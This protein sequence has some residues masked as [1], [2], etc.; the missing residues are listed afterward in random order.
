[1]QHMSTKI[2]H[3]PTKGE[4]TASR[5]TSKCNPRVQYRLMDPLIDKFFHEQD[6]GLIVDQLKEQLVLVEQNS[7]R[8]APFK[9]NLLFP[10]EKIFTTSDLIEVLNSIRTMHEHLSNCVWEYTQTPE[11]EPSTYKKGQMLFKATQDPELDPKSIF[12]YRCDIEPEL[13]Y[14][15]HS[16]VH[17]GR[18]NID[19]GRIGD[20]GEIRDVSTKWNWD[21]LIAETKGFVRN[22]PMYCR[23]HV[24]YDGSAKRLEIVARIDKQKPAPFT[25]DW[26]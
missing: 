21:A 26:K 12:E 18:L 15:H 8:T 10:K 9:K 19:C 20:D 3:T 13:T 11:Y 1:M 4:V 7:R 5:N 22:S 17:Y 24:N 14:F 6:Y 25:P 2:K 16:T 23:E